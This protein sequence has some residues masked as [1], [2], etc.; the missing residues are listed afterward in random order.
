MKRF[1]AAVL[2]VVLSSTAAFAAWNIRQ[3][4]DGSTDMVY[5]DGQATWRVG[6]VTLQGSLSNVSTASTDFVVSPI[7]GNITGLWIAIERAITANTTFVLTA[8]STG[9]SSSRRPVS[10][11][12][13]VIAPGASTAVS[14][15]VSTFIP[16]AAYSVAKDTVITINSNGTAAPAAASNARVFVQIDP[17]PQQ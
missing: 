3:N 6:R 7:T 13:T 17:Y 4:D 10:T 5:N 9:A 8:Q 16:G 2:A 15:G 14:W 1:L 12:F 11:S